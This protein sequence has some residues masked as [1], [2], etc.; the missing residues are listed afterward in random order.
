MRFIDL[1]WTQ[2]RLKHQTPLR[3]GK[4]FDEDKN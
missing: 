3:N 4:S 1:P 2:E